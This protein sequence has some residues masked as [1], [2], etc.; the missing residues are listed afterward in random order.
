[1]LHLSQPSVTRRHRQI[2]DGVAAA[3]T[4]M[5]QR[6]SGPAEKMRA[7]VSEEPL[8][9]YATALPLDAR[10]MCEVGLILK[11]GVLVSSSRLGEE[12]RLMKHNHVGKVL[13]GLDPDVLPFAS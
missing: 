3:E 8:F 10:T 9:K 7:A 6:T 12:S 4:V 5:T 13:Q 1:M 2:G 11:H